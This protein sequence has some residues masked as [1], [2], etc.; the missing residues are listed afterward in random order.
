MLPGS[1]IILILDFLFISYYPDHAIFNFFLNL[2]VD[3]VMKQVDN[4]YACNG[5][6]GAV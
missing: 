5:V 1:I 2:F 6:M 4:T 3:V